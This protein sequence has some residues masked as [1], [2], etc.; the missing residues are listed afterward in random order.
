MP[1]DSV[2][3]STIHEFAH[4]VVLVRA[5]DIDALAPRCV[6]EARAV[7]LAVFDHAFET[8]ANHAAQVSIPFGALLVAR[9]VA[10][11]INDPAR[12]FQGVAEIFP[13]FSS[14]QSFTGPIRH[15]LLPGLG[16]PFGK[17]DSEG[18]R[19]PDTRGSL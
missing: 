15:A 8:I 11:F 1:G 13:G 19:L 3:M 2:L 14:N 6:P 10:K 5:L 16:F 7:G 17:Y 12:Y 9:F 4:E 18:K